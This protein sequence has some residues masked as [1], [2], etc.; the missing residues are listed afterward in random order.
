MC[1]MVMWEELPM[2]HRFDYL[3]RQC[4]RGRVIKHTISI[5]FKHTIMV[6]LKPLSVIAPL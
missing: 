6:F 2:V 3:A 5:S 1:W 4:L